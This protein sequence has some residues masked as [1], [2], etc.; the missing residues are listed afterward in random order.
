MTIRVHQ[1]AKVDNTA[2]KLRIIQAS[3]WWIRFFFVTLY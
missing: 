3:I 1:M 2:V